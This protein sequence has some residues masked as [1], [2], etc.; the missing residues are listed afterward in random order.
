M[1]SSQITQLVEQAKTGNKSSLEQLLD[2]F[3][4]D[5]FR[6]VYYRVSYGMDAE[7]LLI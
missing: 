1:K 7:D 4:V 3:Y 5:I 6:M 2:H